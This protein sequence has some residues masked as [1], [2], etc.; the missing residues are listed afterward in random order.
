MYGRQIFKFRDVDAC[1]AQRE[2][3]AYEYRHRS[4]IIKMYPCSRCDWNMSNHQ[5]R[6]MS[7]A[8][9][10][11]SFRFSASRIG[12][13]LLDDT[14]SLIDMFFNWCLTNIFWTISWCLEVVMHFDF[15]GC[16][17]DWWGFTLH[18]ATSLFCRVNPTC[19]LQLPKVHGTYW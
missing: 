15:L 12:N 4:V 6:F 18:P 13:L 2:R 5:G 1:P 9:M 19:L 17:C 3:D 11:I 8:E 16:S 14:K 7:E 10:T